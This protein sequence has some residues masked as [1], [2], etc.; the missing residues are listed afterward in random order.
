MNIVQC[1]EFYTLKGKKQGPPLVYDE[2]R[3][4]SGLKK[5]RRTRE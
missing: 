1:C 3:D 5:I 4:E 2:K